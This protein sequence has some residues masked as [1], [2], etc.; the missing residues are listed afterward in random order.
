VGAPEDARV[1]LLSRLIDHAPLFPPASL[2]LAEAVAEDRRA[3]EDAAAF[4]LARFV[5]PASRLA[6]LPDVG[7]RVSVVLDRGAP[8]PAIVRNGRVKAVEMRMPDDLQLLGAF[9]A[10]G[11][12]IYVEVPLDDHLE[13]RLD[14]LSEL[15]LRVKVRCGGVSV[16]TAAELAR[17]VRGCAARRL[18]F[19]ATAGLHHAVRRG[20]EHGLLNL[21]AAMVFGYEEAALEER[22]PSAFWLDREEFA[23]RHRSA[24]AAELWRLRQERLTA[25]G[26]CSFFEPIG[27][28]AALGMLPA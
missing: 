2:P 16:P 11:I 7:R 5:C 27:E 14:A 28:L 26:S 17:L 3:R 13:R 23:W 25:V 24:R 22:D 1:A 15:G 8:D 18:A 4:S 12:E 10:L 9:A 6:D 20:G 21:L 19:K